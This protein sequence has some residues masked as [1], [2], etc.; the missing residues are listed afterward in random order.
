MIKF[1]FIF[2]VSSE[3]DVSITKKAVSLVSNIDVVPFQLSN[4]YFVTNGNQ[5][6]TGKDLKKVKSASIPFLHC[7]GTGRFH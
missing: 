7:D 4:E 6:E 5:F 1:V 2:E 3:I